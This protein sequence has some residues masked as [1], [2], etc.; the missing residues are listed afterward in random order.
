M[1]YM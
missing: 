1:Y